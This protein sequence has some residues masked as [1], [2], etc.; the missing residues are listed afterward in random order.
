MVQACVAPQNNAKSLRWSSEDHNGRLWLMELTKITSNAHM[1][2]FKH[3][4]KT[5]AA[6]A[7]LKSTF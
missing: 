2:Q 1:L 6:L 7:I 5:H 4:S 3:D